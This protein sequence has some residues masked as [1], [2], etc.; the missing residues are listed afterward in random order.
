MVARRAVRELNLI[1]HTPATGSPTVTII[2]DSG[3]D[4]TDSSL[5]LLATALGVD[6]KAPG[7]VAAAAPTTGA[8][9]VGEKVYNS[10]PVA[11]GTIGWVCTTAGTPGTW[12]TFGAIAA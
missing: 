5:A 6:G 3:D 9:V 8:H 10:T 12:K 1:L 7:V 4:M 2:N 11:G